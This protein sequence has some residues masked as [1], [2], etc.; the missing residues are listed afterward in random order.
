MS[1]PRR[2]G[3]DQRTHRSS[4]RMPGPRS[5]G[6]MVGEGVAGSRWLPKLEHSKHRNVTLVRC[7]A[8]PSFL[9]VPH[10]QTA[11]L[12]RR[13]RHSRSCSAAV[14]PPLRLQP[15]N[16]LASAEDGFVKLIE[17]VVCHDHV[18]FAT[19]LYWYATSG[20]MKTFFDRLTDLMLR[21]ENKP[22]GRA[23]AGRNAWALVNGT[24]LVP[25]AGISE[26]VART[27]T[28]FDMVWRG[29]RYLQAER[30]VGFKVETLSSLAELA[31]AITAAS[32]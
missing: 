26:P 23:L 4:R 5:K 1:R 15:F 12:Q 32:S 6:V 20:V 22:L 31:D 2:W 25:P 7:R 13:L 14:R 3:R 18:V 10:G 27:A 30:Q 24:D 28:Y 8:R 29:M 21:A 17:Q 11:I 19:P 16:Y 9:W